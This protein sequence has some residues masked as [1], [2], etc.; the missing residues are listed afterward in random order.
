M[1]IRLRTRQVREHP[2]Q[3]DRVERT[4]VEDQIAREILEVHESTYGVGAKETHVHIVGDF[5][6]VALD[7]ELTRAEETLLV[8]DRTEAVTGIRESFQ[9]VIG[10][11]FCAIVERATGRRV[12]SFISQMNVDPLYSIELFRLAPGD[13]PH[14]PEPQ[15]EALSGF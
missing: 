1:G 3:M 9:K 10:A 13:G 14:P 6:L 12:V 4:Q 2:L 8:A 5:V 7:V 11:T 15:T